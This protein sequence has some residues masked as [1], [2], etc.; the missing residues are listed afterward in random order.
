M[1]YMSDP[2]MTL[3]NNLSMVTYGTPLCL[4]FKGFLF[5]V[6]YV[7]V[8]SQGIGSPTYQSTCLYKTTSISSK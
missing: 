2:H 4:Y 5:L 7:T 8:I 6:T 1:N 3:L